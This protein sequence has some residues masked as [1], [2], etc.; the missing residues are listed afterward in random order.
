[1]T[2]ASASSRRLPAS[3]PE[4][5]RPPEL[6]HQLRRPHA[7][8]PHGKAAAQVAL[9][10]LNLALFDFVLSSAEMIRIH[11]IDGRMVSPDGLAP[12]GDKAA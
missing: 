2:G 6:S 3:P 5:Y 7:K 8:R 11:R 12:A 9:R 4:T 1:M 10:Q